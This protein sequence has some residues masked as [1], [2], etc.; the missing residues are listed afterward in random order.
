MTYIPDPPLWDPVETPMWSLI[1]RSM[2]GLAIM[3]LELPIGVVVATLPLG[4]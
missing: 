4:P 2:P 3:H 1:S